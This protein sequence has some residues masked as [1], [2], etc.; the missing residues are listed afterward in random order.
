MMGKNK[1]KDSEF[2]EETDLNLEKRKTELEI[3]EKEET[4]LATDKK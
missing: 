3:V 1:V 4:S 2:K